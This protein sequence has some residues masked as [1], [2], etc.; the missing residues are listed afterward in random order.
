M[1]KT[2]MRRAWAIP[3]TAALT[4]LTAFASSDPAAAFTPNSPEVQEA[5][6]R[7][8][9][10]LE[11]TEFIDNRVGALALA[12][13]A[14]LK[15]THDS[16]HAKVVQAVQVIRGE[17]GK[18]AD[19]A[20][21]GVLDVY[22]T[23]LSIIF[24]VD[25]DPALYRPEI[26]QILGYLQSRQQAQGAWGYPRS[27]TTGD[28][29]MTQYGVLSSWEAKRAGFQVPTESIERATSWLMKTQQ[30]EGG[31]RYHATAVASSEI[32][33]EEDARVTLSMTAA[34]L[35]SLY[36]CADLLGQTGL[37][38][39][40]REEDNLPAFLKEVA[41]EKSKPVRKP[42]TRINPRLI[43]DAQS[44]GNRWM[45]ANYSI[46]T[47][48]FNLYYLYALERY[49]SF[50]EAAEGRSPAEP[51]WYNDGVRFLLDS[52]RADGG[53]SD[54]CLPVP[55][56]A[57]GVLFL[58]RSTKTSIQRTKQSTAGGVLIGG[59]GL[60]RDTDQVIVR[61]G[62]VE[63]RPLLGPAE[64]LLAALNDPKVSK[65]SQA[66]ERLA[67]LP[68]EERQELISKHAAK[69]RQ[70]AG[71]RSPEARIAAVR[72]LGRSGNLRHVPTLVYALTD[73]DPAVVRQARD[74]LRRLSRKFGG[75][76][77]PDNPSK[78][79]L[80][81]AIGKWKAWYLAIKA[82]AEFED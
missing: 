31:F 8:I 49:W 60:P 19:P 2:V 36:V 56:T 30:P 78:A 75:F 47:G 9:Q 69:L 17:L 35:G 57:F 37:A 79:Q 43:W 64:G 51:Q 33:T 3:V 15:H 26:E 23:G 67:E 63:A 71:G 81:E 76:A 66:L 38:E 34:G 74:A 40:T 7:A 80:R 25:L 18:L 73:P 27:K 46:R 59:R 6:G 52:Q 16:E 28:T 29:S 39:Q 41:S 58:L 21:P 12:G 24:L 61:D 22:S 82:D 4:M 20:Q 55:A 13:M 14:I 44:R 11:G 32:I 77:L 70:M 42:S 10:F 50:R 45:E 68:L 1:E 5:L 48:R 65:V 62:K 54:A 53:W 72:A